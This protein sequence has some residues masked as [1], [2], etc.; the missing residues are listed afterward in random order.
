MSILY[1]IPLL[2]LHLLLVA[3]SVFSSLGGYLPNTSSSALHFNDQPTISRLLYFSFMFSISILCTLIPFFSFTLCAV[4]SFVLLPSSLL[5]F[6]SSSCFLY[7][8]LT[9]F[10]FVSFISRC[11]SFMTLFLFLSLPSLLQL[12][13]SSPSLYSYSFACAWE[14]CLRRERKQKCNIRSLWKL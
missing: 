7:F 14:Y 11:L 5:P 13:S 4:P 1:L 6:V 8:A 9:I 3:P 12:S 2:L 10:V